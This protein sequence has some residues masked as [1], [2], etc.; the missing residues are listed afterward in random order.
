MLT[1]GDLHLRW[2]C[3]EHCILRWTVANRKRMQRMQAP[4]RMLGARQNRRRRP[5]RE[6]QESAAQCEH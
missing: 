5:R 4:L 1:E 3:P 6:Q 2:R